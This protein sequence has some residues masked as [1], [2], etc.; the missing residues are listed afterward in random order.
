VRDGELVVFESVRHLALV[1]ERRTGHEREEWIVD[2]RDEVR[3]VDDGVVRT[4][5]QTCAGGL[6]DRALIVAGGEGVLR[7]GS[8]I[9]VAELL[10]ARVGQGGAFPRSDA[11]GAS[12][13]H[14]AGADRG[15]RGHLADVRRSGDRPQDG[16]SGEQ[17]RAAQYDL[18]DGAWHGIPPSGAMCSTPCRAWSS[19]TARAVPPVSP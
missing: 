16:R 5:A 1:D 19:C 17:Q 7:V 14:L 18:G 10:S 8:C 6:P 4:W 9:P 11:A 13:T 15:L 2:G 12:R 3:R